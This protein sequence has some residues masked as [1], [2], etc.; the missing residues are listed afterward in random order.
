MPAK[1]RNGVATALLLAASAAFAAQLSVEGTPTGEPGMDVSVPIAI[2]DADG[3]VGFNFEVSFSTLVLD[4]VGV[5]KGDLTSGWSFFQSNHAS[6]S[7][8]VTVA[9]LNSTALSGSGT[10]AILHFQVKSGASLGTTTPIQF[11]TAALNDGQIATT[12]INGQVAVGAVAQLMLPT[13][14]AAAPGE[15]LTIPINV[16]DA[17]GVVG[18]TFDLYFDSILID[19]PQAS[20]GALTSGW[21]IQTNP[22]GDHI[23][24]AALNTNALSGGGVMANVTLHMKTTAADGTNATV[25]IQNVEMND[26]DIAAAGDAGA[27]TVAALNPVYVDFTA[28]SDGDGQPGTP[29]K[30][31]YNAALAVKASTNNPGIIRINPGTT[32]ETLTTAGLN[33]HFR[34]ERNGASGVVTIGKISTK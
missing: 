20:L 15:Q 5:D 12:T 9:G 8:T 34:I 18:F 6:G 3:V 31:V 10:L 32:S 1:V 22:Q 24:V 27:V 14:L 4:F 23:S 28:A 2:D 30:H 29:Y 16:D 21:N 25:T 17:T 33:K 26:G 13:N 7:A 19:T 11:V